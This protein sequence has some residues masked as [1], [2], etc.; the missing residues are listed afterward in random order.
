MSF[1]LRLGSLPLWFWLVCLLTFFTGCQVAPSMTGTVDISSLLGSVPG[2]VTAVVGMVKAYSMKADSDS[3]VA[4]AT[5]AA[6]EAR[7]EVDA[8]VA[9]ALLNRD[10]EIAQLRLLVE[11]ALGREG[12]CQKRLDALDRQ[13]REFREEHLSQRSDK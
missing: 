12:K 3:K 5:A 11:A 4:A 6:A 13:F 9:Q 2:I 8:A 1:A 10:A 7:A